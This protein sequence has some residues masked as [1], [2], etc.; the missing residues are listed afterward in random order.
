VIHAAAA[1]GLPVRCVW[2]STSVED[3]QVNAVWRMLY[4]Y[5]RLLGPG[6][7]R[8]ITK[9]DVNAFG[10]AVQFR[11]VRDLEPPH[12]SEG[13]SRIDIVPFERVHDPSLTDRALIVWCDGFEMSAEQADVL[14]RHADAGWRVLGLAW[15]PEVGDDEAA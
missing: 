9:Q 12:E 8:K 3:A 5:G 4:K 13:F 1:A 15:R 2:L 10:P 11:Y 7:M 14:R 6:E